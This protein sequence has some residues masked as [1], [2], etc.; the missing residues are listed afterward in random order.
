VTDEFNELQQQYFDAT[1]DERERLWPDFIRAISKASPGLLEAYEIGSANGDY[2]MI[3]FV[4][5]MKRVLARSDLAPDRKTNAMEDAAN[6]MALFDALKQLPPKVAALAFAMAETTLFTGLRA[7]LTPDE[8]DEL[9]ARFTTE[10]QR[11]RGVKSGDVRRDKAWREFAKEAALR[12][13]EANGALTLT[14]IARKVENKWEPEKF[15]KVELQQLFKYLSDRVD[16]GELPSSMK[17]R[18]RKR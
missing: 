15:E 6:F 18:A 4:Q 12:L 11:K 17:R 3:V 14:D 8:V 2:L 7:G 13:H 9:Q 16:K 10:H 1:P 5:C